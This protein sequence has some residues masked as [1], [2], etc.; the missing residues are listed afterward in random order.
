MWIFMN[1]AFVSIVQHYDD[2][3]LLVVRGRLPG[4]VERAVPAALGH[5]VRTPHNDYAYRAALPRELVA[6][7]VAT[8]LLAVDYPNFKASAE[9]VKP[10]RPGYV[11]ALHEV[12][13]IMFRL[14]EAAS[15]F[16]SRGGRP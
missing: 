6:Q 7:A 9:R 14:Q 16:A 13:S 10:A 5:V 12:W 2:P 15:R 8:R 11:H 1:D 3:A 4:D